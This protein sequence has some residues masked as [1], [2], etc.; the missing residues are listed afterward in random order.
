MGNSMAMNI[1]GCLFSEGAEQNQDEAFKYFKLSSDG[2][3]AI[4]MTNLSNCY[5]E[6]A[7]VP[8]DEKFGIKLSQ[9]AADLNSIYAIKN[10]IDIYSYKPKTARNL[11]LLRHLKKREVELDGCC[12]TDEAKL[13]GLL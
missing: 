7:G 6:G 8:R 4:G 12:S 2:G 9:Q 5:I 11:D 3:C 1:M 13:R 10:L